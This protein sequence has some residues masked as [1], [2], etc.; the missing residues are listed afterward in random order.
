MQGHERY[1]GFVAGI[2]KCQKELDD[3]TVI[4]FTTSETESLFTDHAD[5]ILKRLQGCGGIV[6]YNDQIAYSL[7]KLLENHGVKVPEDVA[8]TGC[9]NANL[10]EY[11]S[12]KITTFD[13][14][15]EKMGITAADKIINLV[16]NTKP[17]KSEVLKMNRIDK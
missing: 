7:I 15:K 8:V 4:W 6:C 11:S 3:D 13:H 14:P 2:L 17:E 1:A 12:L 9:D 16:E 10:L 5:T